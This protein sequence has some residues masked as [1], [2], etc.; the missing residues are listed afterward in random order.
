MIEKPINKNRKTPSGNVLLI[1][2]GGSCCYD[3]RA[4]NN[5]FFYHSQKHKDQVEKRVNVKLL[6]T[7]KGSEKHIV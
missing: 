7:I 3:I 5:L 6:S 4:N 1:G 2:T